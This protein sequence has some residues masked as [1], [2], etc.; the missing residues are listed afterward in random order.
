M[1][2]GAGN[3]AGEGEISSAACHTLADSGAEAGPSGTAPTGLS[4][5]AQPDGSPDCCPF[6]LTSSESQGLEFFVQM[7]AGCSSDSVIP[8]PSHARSGSM[9]SG[10]Q[11]SGLKLNFFF[12]LLCLLG[13]F[14]F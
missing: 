10:S 12:V 2:G 4:S 13:F 7:A 1:G 8:L 14:F 5:K 3:V 9:G 6:L 11:D